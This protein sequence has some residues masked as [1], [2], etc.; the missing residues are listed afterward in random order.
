MEHILGMSPFQTKFRIHFLLQYIFDSELRKTPSTRPLHSSGV[1]GQAFFNGGLQVWPAHLHPGH[2]LWP[3]KDLP[4]QWRLGA[5]GN[6]EV[7]YTQWVQSGKNAIHYLNG[8]E[9]VLILGL[10][11]PSITSLLNCTLSYIWYPP[12]IYSPRMIN[13]NMISVRRSSGYNYNVILSVTTAM[14]IRRTDLICC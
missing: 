12:P 6:R 4:L 2:F 13:G 10:I 3:S 9:T 11:F 8:K 5:D 14:P 1:L 7:S